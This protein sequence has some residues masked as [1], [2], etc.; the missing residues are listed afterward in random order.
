[1]PVRH[2]AC[3]IGKLRQL[4][5]ENLELQQTSQISFTYSWESLHISCGRVFFLSLGFLLMRSRAKPENC[6]RVGVCVCV[7]VDDLN[8]GQTGCWRFYQNGLFTHPNC[9]SSNSRKRLLIRCHAIAR[10]WSIATQSMGIRVTGA[11]WCTRA[12]LLFA[13]TI[14]PTANACLPFHVCRWVL[15]ARCTIYSLLYCTYRIPFMLFGDTQ[16][17]RLR[18][19]FWCFEIEFLE[20]E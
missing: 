10:A 7:C 13:W 2:D 4:K 18:T 5:T 15:T 9:G 19:R 20:K 16:N 1:M 8:A 17:K 14:S 11:A 6:T 3:K 12:L